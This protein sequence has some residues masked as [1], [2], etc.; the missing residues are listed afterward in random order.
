[1]THDS[2]SHGLVKSKLWLCEQLEIALDNENIKNPAVNI[3][4]GWDSL[5]AFMLLSRRPQF[6]GVVNS[7]DIDPNATELA[8]KLCDHW[9]YEYPKVY[10]HTKDIHT[11]DFSNTGKESIFI[12]CSVD[13]LKTTSWY[14]NIPAGRLV[15]L[16]CTDL[17]TSHNNWNVEQSYSDIGQFIDA[18]KMDRLAYAD[19][20]TINYDHLKY[21]RYMIIGIK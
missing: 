7:Y 18:Y 14:D 8:N 13:Q 15:C 2:F 11:L 9:I 10:N 19:Y 21:K 3:L 17:P 12:N 4:A 20:I 5:L 16:Q 1:M 6:Y